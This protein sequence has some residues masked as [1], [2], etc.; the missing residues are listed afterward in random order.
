MISFNCFQFVMVYKL[1]SS[2][3][4][5]H[6]VAKNNSFWTDANGRQYLKRTINQRES[7][8]VSQKDFDGEFASANYYPITSGISIDGRS[9]D[10]WMDV[11]IDRAQGAASLKSD[12]IEIMVHRRLMYD[13]GRGERISLCF[14][15]NNCTELKTFYSKVLVNRWTNSSLEKDWSPEESTTFVWESR[16]IVSHLAPTYQHDVT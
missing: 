4:S 15:H 11:L 8:N 5:S 14:M 12:E 13:D 16:P 3:S 1:P 10:E 6:S 7:Y 9:P 2:A